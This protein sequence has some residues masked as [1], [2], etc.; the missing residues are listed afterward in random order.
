M[1]FRE[2][3]KYLSRLTADQLDSDIVVETDGKFYRVD[4]LQIASGNGDYLYTNDPFFTTD[5]Q[6]D[7]KYPEE[8]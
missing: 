6:L 3:N 5:Y 2:L 7:E 1:T 8:E 4:D